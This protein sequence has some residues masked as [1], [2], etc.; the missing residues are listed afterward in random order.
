MAIG[1][2]KAGDKPEVANI[3]AAVFFLRRF[4]LNGR[5]EDKEVAERTARFLQSG[6]KIVLDPGRAELVLRIREEPVRLL[7][8]TGNATRDEAKSR[9]LQMA[10]LNAPVPEVVVRYLDGPPTRSGPLAWPDAVSHDAKSPA[11]YRWIAEGWQ[12]PVTDPDKLGDIL[13][14]SAV[15]P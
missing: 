10:A 4:W 13:D 12:G 1:R 8:L 9:K 7:L 15:D 5:R 14:T 6:D 2:L 11:I 3:Q